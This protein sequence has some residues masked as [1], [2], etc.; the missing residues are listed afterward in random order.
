[1][2]TPIN[3]P[4]LQELAE[5]FN[6]ELRQAPASE[7]RPNHISLNAEHAREGGIFA[8]LPGTR[9]HGAKFAE[10]TKASAIL[11]DEAGLE[12]LSDTESRPILVASD[13]RAILGPV[14][15]LIFGEPSKRLNII[16]ITGTSGKTTTTYLLEAICRSFGYSTGL[17]GTTGT[18]INGQPVETALT[19]PE[20]PMLQ[21]LFATMVEQGV[22]HV[23]MEVSSHAIALGRV[24]GTQFAV[25]AFT[26]LSQ[27]HLDFHPTMEDYFE[28]KASFFDADPETCV[29]TI[30]DEWGRKLATRTQGHTVGFSAGFSPV[31]DVAEGNGAAAEFAVTGV[32]NNRDGSQVFT[33]RRG[34]VDWHVSL[35]LPGRFNVQNAALALACAAVDGMPLS[36]AVNALAHVKAPGR[37]ERIDAGQDF[38]AV[39]DYA[40]KPAAVKAVLETLRGETKGR[41]GIVLG[42]GGDRDHFKRPIMGAAAVYGADCV[43]V[44]DDN[45]RSEDPA[46]IRAQVMAGANQALRQ[47][48]LKSNRIIEVSECGDRAEAIRRMVAWARPGDAIVI[49]GKGHETGQ[50]IGDEK[51]HFDDREEL[52]AA[53]L[54]SLS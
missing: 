17:I 5:Q 12:F 16:G 26:N 54:E 19:T 3:S 4:S 8:A 52:R 18:R 21:E 48:S 53:L 45:P 23:V 1:M 43:I 10:G 22:S 32:K 24:A 25:R 34:E 15:S 36:N 30:D 13:I 14:S 11:T 51:I 29:I 9:T 27:D 38:L 46:A 37:L 49:A 39:V 33:F 44:T 41:L 2:N 7:L 40:H 28:T 47:E 50:Q 31:D 42:A 35:E 6:L 20:A